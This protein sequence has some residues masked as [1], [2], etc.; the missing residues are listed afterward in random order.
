MIHKIYFKNNVKFDL[1]YSDGTNNVGRWVF[2]PYKYILLI[3]ENGSGKTHFLEQIVSIAK[4]QNKNVASV[5]TNVSLYPKPGYPYMQT[6]AQ[7]FKGL[8]VDFIEAITTFS[9]NVTAK[10]KGINELTKIKEKL[11]LLWDE[12]RYF[13]DHP[14]ENT[15]KINNFKN[16]NKLLRSL[17]DDQEMV[18]LS[19]L[20]NKDRKSYTFYIDTKHKQNLDALSG[21]QQKALFYAINMHLF[22]KT[23]NYI[24]LIDEPENNWHPNLQLKFIDQ[25]EINDSDKKQL[26]VATHSPFIVNS[27]LNKKREDTLII[28]FYKDKDGSFKHDYI[29]GDNCMLP[30]ISLGEIN[31]I[32]YKL[33]SI[34]FHIQLF[35]YLQQ[36]YCEKED[37]KYRYLNNFNEK[38]LSLIPN[39]PELIKTDPW[40][41]A[42]NVALPIYIRNCIDHPENKDRTQYTY[43]ELVTSTLLLIELINEA[44]KS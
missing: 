1:T 41:E 12:D 42:H 8:I 35:G 6:T 33:Y 4:G 34:D 11:T 37:E 20:I 9:A 38:L 21:G 26:I 5:E 16:I 15:T 40:P 27:F 44:K 23:Q 2:K 24:L 22:L 36:I 14:E 3:G 7:C 31:Y 25:F 13:S 19:P 10:N 28:N 32:A 17:L 29:Q 18:T 30:F 43:N 39:K